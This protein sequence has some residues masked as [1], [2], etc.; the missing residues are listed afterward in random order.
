MLCTSVF[1]Y[2]EWNPKKNIEI[3]TNYNIYFKSERIIANDKIK[4]TEVVLNG[5]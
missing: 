1:Y 4:N 3:Y 5:L 2:V